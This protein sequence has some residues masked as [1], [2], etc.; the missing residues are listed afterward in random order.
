MDKLKLKD[1]HILYEKNCKQIF[2]GQI[3]RSII[4]S[5]VKYISEEDGSNVNP[6]PYYK[7][8]YT[9]IDTLDYSIYFKTDNKT[10]YVFWDNTFIS[11]GLQSKLIDLTDTTNDYEQKWDV[12]KDL[13]WTD[14]IGQKIVDFK[15]IWKE[16]SSSNLNGTNKVNIMYPQ[17]FIIKTENGKIIIISAS[18]LDHDEE[19]KVFPL[20]DNLLITTNIDLA[21][22]LKLID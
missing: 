12:S 3:I 7:T 22:Q 21:K 11:Y 15:I 8:K 18:E 13:K 6:E 10:I 16:T 14:I 1:K 9:D 20:M 17:S 19:D 5:E 4:Y 2:V